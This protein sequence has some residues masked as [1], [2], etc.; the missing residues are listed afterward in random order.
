M[1]N[2][3]KYISRS[4]NLKL[5]IGIIF[6][7]SLFYFLINLRFINLLVT[8]NI[9]VSPF[10][11]SH[12]K[13]NI[14]NMD[15]SQLGD[16][17]ATNFMHPFFCFIQLII[18]PF[19][20]SKYGLYGILLIQSLINSINVVLIY[21]YCNNLKTKKYTAIL[22]SIFFGVF[23]Y[24][25]N[26]ALVPD[27]YIYAQSFL[28]MSL[29]YMQYCKH[30][31]KYGI[32]GHAIL[33]VLNFSI[34]VSN[35]ASYAIAVLINKSEPNTKT[36]IKKIVQSI[37]IALGIIILLGFIQ[38]LLFN[39]N[40]TSNIFHSI[41][42]GGL[43][44]SMPFDLKANWKI[45]YLMFTAPI[46]TGPLR[47]M[48]ELQAIVTNIGIKFP[49]SLKLI[50][51]VLL[52]LIL[53]SIIYNIKNKEMWVLS[54]F[55]IVAF[56]IHVIKGFGLAVFEYDMYLYAGHYIF[57]VPMYLAFLSKKLE[58]KKIFKIFTI[59]LVIITLIT[60]INNIF[61]QNEMLNLVK[62][63]YL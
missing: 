17:S 29:V 43:N 3:K 27:S 11:Y 48:P 58:S 31:K 15:P 21:I 33:G 54:S 34:T 62:Q 36:W 37:L 30:T 13:F 38:Q 16:I 8:E 63:T 39:S 49:L 26:S 19:K 59:I 6:S 61:M 12:F 46:I 40:F 44:Y 22:L 35:A 47:V 52:I 41:N 32:I 24:S 42:T 55:L 20:T 23:S 45:I 18:S 25:I 28:I 5:A 10:N 50:T 60:L 56:F 2:F 14:F 57:V 7:F 51:V 4:I 53:M 9:K 1:N